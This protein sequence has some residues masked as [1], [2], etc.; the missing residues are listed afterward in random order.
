[1]YGLD[2]RRE[3]CEALGVAPPD[4]PVDAAVLCAPGGAAEAAHA[5]EPGGTLLVFADAGELDLDAV[6]RAELYVIGSRSA[7]PRHLRRAADLLPELDLPAPEVL[8]LERFAE[9]LERY[10][11]GDALKVVFT[12]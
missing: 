6:Y 11:S 4:G 10:R 1:V 9:G 3:R 12:P 8:P 5:L 7:T 2:P